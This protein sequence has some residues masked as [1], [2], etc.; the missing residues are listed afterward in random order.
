LPDILVLP[1]HNLPFRGEVARA[2]GADGVDR[3][4]RQAA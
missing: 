4:L 3:F 1:S 2:T